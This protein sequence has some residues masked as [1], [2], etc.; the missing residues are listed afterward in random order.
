MGNLLVIIIFVTPLIFLYFGMSGKF[1]IFKYMAK[2]N[3][4]I[5]GGN[6]RTFL[7]EEVFESL[8]NKKT[9]LLI[10]GGASAGY[11]SIYFADDKISLNV[12]QDRYK[13]EARFLNALNQSGIIGVILDMLLLFIPA[14]FAINRSNNSFSKLLGLYLF[15]S[16]PLYFLEMPLSLN[17]DYFLYYFVI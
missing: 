9:N 11:Q 3:Q 14:Y 13:A 16:W 4:T 10:G 12:E 6:T 7:Y 2:D 5:L 15:S 8:K 1:D 17:V